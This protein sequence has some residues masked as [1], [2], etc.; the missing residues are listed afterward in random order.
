MLYVG[1]Y[2]TLSIKTFYMLKMKI[3]ALCKPQGPSLD[4]LVWGNEGLTQRWWCYLG[5][6]FKSQR[7]R[8]TEWGEGLTGHVT[9]DIPMCPELIFLLS[10]LLEYYG[11]WCAVWLCFHLY[12]VTRAANVKSTKYPTMFCCK[13]SSPMLLLCQ[14][15]GSDFICEGTGLTFAKSGRRAL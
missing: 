6:D 3:W 11:E 1:D 12:I 10:P 4:L 14:S 8:P 7:L 5:N 15:G 13:P 9:G 2:F